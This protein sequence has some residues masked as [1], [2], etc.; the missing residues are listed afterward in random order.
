[1]ALQIYERFAYR[2]ERMR[3]VEERLEEAADATPAFEDADETEDE[4]QSAAALMKKHVVK[5]DRSLV[6]SLAEDQVAEAWRSDQPL[7]LGPYLSSVTVELLHWR[8]FIAWMRAR[9]GPRTAPVV[10]VS[11]GRVDTWY[12]GL[13]SRYF[14]VCDLLPFETYMTHRQETSFVMV[15]PSSRRASPIST[16]S[17]STRWPHA[18][19]PPRPWCCTRRC[20]SGSARRSATARCRSPG[21]PSTRATIGSTHLRCRRA[22][23]PRR[24]RMW[25]PVSGTATAFQTTPGIGRSWTM[26]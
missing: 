13:V 14:D 11:R 20:S 19:A 5:V 15:E 25:P 16:R 9:F 24:N 10:A 22:T 23:P 6:A 3:V 7:I 12:S 21:C 26:R 1:M 2:M 4:V 18:W 17:C 8:P